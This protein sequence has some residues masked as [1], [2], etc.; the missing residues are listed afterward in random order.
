MATVKVFLEQHDTIEDVQ[1][2]LF[3]ALSQ[4]E[5]GEVHSEETF[6]QPAARAVYDK[7]MSEHALMWERMLRE[8]S[9]VI[10]AEV[11]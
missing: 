8:I 5:S 11:E 1:E 2:L 4:H 10:D 6:H 9:E 7:M 3:K